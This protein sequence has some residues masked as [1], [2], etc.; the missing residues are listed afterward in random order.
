MKFELMDRR[1]DI[2]TESTTTDEFGAETNVWNVVHSVYAQQIFGSSSEREDD[3]METNNQR[4][5]FIIRYQPNI[6]TKQRVVVDE[7]VFDII[8]VDELKRREILKITCELR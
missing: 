8:S 3:E 2:Q 7:S 4:M 5:T 1:I 6:T